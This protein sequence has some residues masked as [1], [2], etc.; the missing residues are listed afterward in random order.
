MVAAQRD[1]MR[2][3]GAGAMAGSL[4]AF[5]TTILCTIALLVEV[6]DLPVRQDRK[7]GDVAVGRRRIGNPD[8]TQ[9]AIGRAEELT[10][11]K[12][13][14]HCALIFVGD[15]PGTIDHEPERPAFENP[16]LGVE[17]DRYVVGAHPLRRAKHHWGTPIGPMRWWRGRTGDRSED[18]RDGSR[19]SHGEGDSSAF[20]W[21]GRR[22]FRPST[23]T[24]H[25]PGLLLCWRFPPA[26][27]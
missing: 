3:E 22:I 26:L 24:S 23:V 12:Q 16:S 7:P 10:P 17:F 5:P 8:V 19:E 25:R 1:Q 4:A 21:Q 13:D 6:F 2:N 27:A 18:D 11:R 9:I 14:G 20:Y 15:S